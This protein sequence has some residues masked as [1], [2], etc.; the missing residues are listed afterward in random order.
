MQ[1]HG[2]QELGSQAN[3]RPEVEQRAQRRLTRVVSWG[4][5]VGIWLTVVSLVSVALLEYQQES[6]RLFL[7]DDLKQIGGAI[8][9]FHDTTGE[10]P[11][12]TRR[13]D[14][15][16]MHG[17]QTALLPYLEQSALFETIDLQE[18]WDAPVNKTAM[19]VAVPV[20]F[21][22]VYNLNRDAVDKGT[23]YGL[24]CF[25][26]NQY[27]IDYAPAKSFSQMTDMK[28]DTILFGEI[29]DQ[30]PP[31]G[32]PGNGRDPKLGINKSPN[33]FGG[34]SKGGTLFTMA[35]GRVEF[36]SEAIDPDLLRLLATPNAGDNPEGNF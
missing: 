18:P 27:V 8:Q 11:I 31:W 2:E 33:G 24:T 32:R 13:E 26:A 19:S 36:V 15:V 20:Y 34:L 17:W 6:R 9:N 23:G 22:L 3:L 10:Y 12:S 5:W 4:L 16:E 14:G 1:D 25:S 7:K 21:R 28:S 35:D 29:R 30:Y